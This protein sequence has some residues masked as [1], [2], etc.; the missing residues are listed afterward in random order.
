MDEFYLKDIT[1][2]YHKNSPIYLWDYVDVIDTNFR[3][4]YKLSEMDGCGFNFVILSN[5]GCM[6]VDE[7]KV[8]SWHPNYTFVSVLF[9]GI[10]YFDGIR[11]LYM[12]S[13]QTDNYGYENYPNICSMAK[14]LEELKK[15]ELKYCND[16]SYK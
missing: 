6:C 3:I 1:H 16:C 12:G 5:D 9:E 2:E 14:A 8:D 10:A 13:N 4:Y 7:T 11:H 15:L